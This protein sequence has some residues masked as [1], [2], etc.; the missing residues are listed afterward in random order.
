MYEY[1]YT[2]L[3]ATISSTIFFMFYKIMSVGQ[4][5]TKE[6]PENHQDNFSVEKLQNYSAH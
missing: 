3:Y 1:E 4:N 5:N 6:F 2:P